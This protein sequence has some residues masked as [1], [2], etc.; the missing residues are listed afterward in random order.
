MRNKQR[1]GPP[2]WRKW[3]QYAAMFEAFYKGLPPSFTVEEYW[4]WYDFRPD[5]ELVVAGL[6]STVSEIHDIPTNHPLYKE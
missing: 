5:V 1:P 3:K 4:T 6:N 2:F